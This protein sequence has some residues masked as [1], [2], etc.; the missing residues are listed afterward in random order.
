MSCCSD[1]KLKKHRWGQVSH[2]V[3]PLGCLSFGGHELSWPLCL[4][5][6]LDWIVGMWFYRGCSGVPERTVGKEET[7]VVEVW[8]LESCWGDSWGFPFQDS[9]PLH[10]I[11]FLCD[12]LALSPTQWMR[13]QQGIVC[14]SVLY[15]FELLE[16]TLPACFIVC[17]SLVT[18]VTL[19]L[20][21]AIR[22]VFQKCKSY[23]QLAHLLAQL[24]LIDQINA[25]NSFTCANIDC[26]SPA[27]YRRRT[28]Y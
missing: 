3:C 20:W 17:I 15:W 27:D 9:H 18:R 1:G 7:T 5:L 19:W 16:V 25:F 13:L 6:R 14:L 12:L 8:Q 24:F 22:Y 4:K 2:L 28:I 11:T 23:P 26:V 21:C 10:N